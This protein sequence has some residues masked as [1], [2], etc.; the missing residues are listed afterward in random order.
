[1]A[2]K[3]ITIAADSQIVITPDRDCSVTIDNVPVT[4]D[5]SCA[6]AQLKAGKTY[7]FETTTETVMS[8]ESRERDELTLDTTRQVTERTRPDPADDPTRER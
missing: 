3:T 5:R 7:T 4:V 6:H 1:M 2:T 8:Y